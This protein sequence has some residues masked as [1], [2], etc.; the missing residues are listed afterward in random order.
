MPF[1]FG[2]TSRYNRDTGLVVLG[3][4]DTG[5]GDQPY[6]LANLYAKAF[7]VQNNGAAP[8]ASGV[9]LYSPDNTV[10]GT[11]IAIAGGTLASA[12]IWTGTM[13][14]TWRYWKIRA[15]VASGSVATV[16]AWINF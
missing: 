3:T 7:Q 11:Y 10:W 12:G 1:M 16:Q 9:L 14:N 8:L 6:D 13:E 2:N 4:V 15:S 5:V